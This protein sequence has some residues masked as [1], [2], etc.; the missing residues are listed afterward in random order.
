ML[1]KIVKNTHEI[2]ATAADFFAFRY[3]GYVYGL[4]LPYGSIPVFCFHGVELNSLDAMLEYLDYNGYTTLD[5]DEYHDIVTRKSAPPRKAVVLTF[6]D[7]WGS[8][9]TIGF[10]LIKKWGAK[11]I[12][13]I[14]PGRIELAG[15]VG[16]NLDDL[17]AGK[18]AREEVFDRDR[19]SMPLLTWEETTVMHESGL[20]DFQSHSYN[21]GLITRS[22]RIVSFLDPSLVSGTGMMELPCPPVTRPIG[23]RAPARLGEPLYE[24]A[25][26]LSD[27][28]RLIVDPLV[29]NGCVQF[30]EEY[31]GKQFFERENWRHELA[32]LAKAL[33]RKCGSIGNESQ[34]EQIEAIRFE[35]AASKRAIEDM[36]PGKTVRHICYPWHVAGRITQNE[37]KAVG[38]KSAFWGKI[39]ERYSNP[40]PADPFKIARMGGDFFYRLPGKGRSSL[41]RILAGKMIRRACQGSPYLT[42]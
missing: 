38:Y 31:G 12:V 16:H 27:I 4:K 41:F 36:L 17:K 30:V 2:A 20:V 7:G 35:L 32:Q 25:P 5:A 13:F 11:I 21:H 8:L 18:C 14:P 40:I 10:P 26:R 23:A 9:W 28:P 24:T 39:D 42:H 15:K 3:P 22:N 34:T 33:L 1:R 37:V 29:A 6:D 19:S